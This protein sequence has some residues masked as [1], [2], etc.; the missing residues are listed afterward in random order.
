M[1]SLKALVAFIGLCGAVMAVGGAVT[2]PAIPVWYD[3]LAKP[4][5]TPPSWAFSVVWPILYL[6]MAVAAWLVWRRA[7]GLG[8]ARGAFLLFGVQLALNLLWSILFFGLMAPG[9]ALVEIVALWLAIAATTVAFWRIEILSGLFFVPY[10]AWVA[11]AILLNAAI[12][13]LN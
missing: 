6:A 10:L 4:S 2:A 8:P 3:G 9:A 7:G 13:R 11:Y 1:A 12:W 5:Y